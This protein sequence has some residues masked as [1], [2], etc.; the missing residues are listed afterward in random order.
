M[1]GSQLRPVRR[2]LGCV[3]LMARI[4]AIETQKRNPDRLTIRLDGHRAFGLAAIVAAGLRVGQDLDAQEIERLHGVDV[5]ESTFQRALHF[6]SFR[7][8][9]E[10]EIEQHLRKREIAED[11]LE[12]VMQ[13]LRQSQLADDSQF[14][15][16]WVENRTTFRPRS[17]RALSWELRRK[18]VRDQEIEAAVSEVDESELAFQAGAKRARQLA[19]DPW[20]DFRRKLYAYLARRGFPSEL[21]GSVVT[22]LW[23]EANP[24]QTVHEN[25]DVP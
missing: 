2:A 8:R 15:Q 19:G 18:G 1:L 21:I 11:V 22:R 6:L 3:C 14:A 10:S 25:E 23:A 13:R 9:S 16:A 12:R 24:V 17:R 7:T 5:E 20:Q 4:T